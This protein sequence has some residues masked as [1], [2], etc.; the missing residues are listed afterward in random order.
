MD[1]NTNF[2]TKETVGS[3]ST[4]NDCMTNVVEMQPPSLLQ[5]NRHQQSALELCAKQQPQN[6]SIKRQEP[7]NLAPHPQQTQDIDR[8]NTDSCI[9]MDGPERYA[10]TE[11]ERLELEAVQ[12]QIWKPKKFVVYR[13]NPSR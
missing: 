4:S 9:T 6:L 5:Q 3:T 13:A 12:K 1:E 8:K 10:I 11:Y 7:S 2:N